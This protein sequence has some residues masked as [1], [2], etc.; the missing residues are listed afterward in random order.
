M[1]NVTKG[2]LK[3]ANAQAI[4]SAKALDSIEQA[5]RGLAL[6]AE[7]VGANAPT[8]TTTYNLGLILGYVNEAQMYLLERS[9][10]DNPDGKNKLI[11]P[12]G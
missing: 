7:E 11:V 1:G 12:G 2:Q 8:P 4:L 5:G 9:R 6:V 3:R 10:H